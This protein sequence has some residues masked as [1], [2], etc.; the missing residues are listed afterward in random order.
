MYLGIDAG[1]TTIKIV[2]CDDDGNIFNPFYSSNEGSPV[3]IVKNY[4]IDLYS[5]IGRAS[6]RERVFRAV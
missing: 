6:C 5:K 2:L 4:L 1:S 3:E